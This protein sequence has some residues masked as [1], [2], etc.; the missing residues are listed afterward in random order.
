MPPPPFLFYFVLIFLFDKVLVV[1]VPVWVENA[2]VGRVPEKL[3]CFGKVLNRDGYSEKVGRRHFSED[4]LKPLEKY[5]CVSYHY[6]W[7]FA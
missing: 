5:S 4:T 2:G 7:L 6:I 1:G 3:T